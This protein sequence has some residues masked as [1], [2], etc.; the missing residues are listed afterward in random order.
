MTRDP[1]T[2]SAQIL[3][4]DD[5]V[6]HAEVMGESLRRQGHVCTIV[7]GR[8]EAE[9]ELQHGNFDLVVTD[10]VMQDEEDGLKVLQK[11]KQTQSNA[12]TIVVTAHGDVPTSVRAIKDGAFHFIAKPLDLNVFRSL[13]DQAIRTVAQRSEISDLRGQLDEQYGFEGIIGNSPAIH[14]IIRT[15]RQVAASDIP[16]L[17]TGGSGTGK[18]LVAK[19]IH[20]NSERARQRFVPLNCAGLSES[21]LEDELFGHVKGAFTGADKDREGRFE[22]ADHGTLF[23]DEVGDMPLIMQA[24]LLRVLESGEVI[25]LGI[26]EPRHV[27]V[28]L[29]SAT[30]RDLGRM[31]EQNEFREDLFFRIKGVELVIPPLRERREDIP[32][33][34]R[35][36]VKSF[37]E[38][39]GRPVPSISEDAQ[40]ILMQ[41]DWPGNVRE[42][43]NVVQSM[44]VIADSDELTARQIPPQIRAASGESDEGRIE[45]TAGMSLEQLEK[46]AIREA[47]RRHGGNREAAARDLGIGERTLYRKLKEYGLK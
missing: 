23:L 12:E 3:I 45:S 8:D 21:I 25:R 14:Q 6:E 10:L 40:H 37:A 5:E 36:Y 15:M 41:Y 44:V 42:L 17:V 28:R 22:Y 27:N 18:E 26:N 39:H 30:N 43:I 16:V 2:P 1:A 32:L 47:L 34:T 4:V 19:A 35:H 9:E 24:K 38:Q 31:V 20:N 33:L 7:H 11:A 46:Q 13:C 29:I